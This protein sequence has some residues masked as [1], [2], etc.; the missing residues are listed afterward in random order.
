MQGHTGGPTLEAHIS[1]PCRCP[2]TLGLLRCWLCCRLC[3]AYALVVA[4]VGTLAC[5]A[6]VPDGAAAGAAAQRCPRLARRL[7][8][9]SMAADEAGQTCSH[10]RLARLGCTA[11]RLQRARQLVPGH[12]R[13]KG[14]SGVCLP[15]L[16]R[17]TQQRLR[18]IQLPTLAQQASQGVDCGAGAAVSGAIHALL[19]C[20]HLAVQALRFL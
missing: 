2:C 18:L 12:C 13:I 7:G 3:P 8:A 15:H 17:P 5:R 14:L 4:P 9:G 11:C 20:Q 19:V 6:T 1:L 10:P 16:H